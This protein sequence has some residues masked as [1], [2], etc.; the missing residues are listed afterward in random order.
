MTDA[1]RKV[2]E[3]AKANGWWTIADPVED[4]IEPDALAAAL[5]AV[6]PA[7]TA[8]RAG[9]SRGWRRIN[10]TAKACPGRPRRA[11]AARFVN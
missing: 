5:D 1:G 9:S 8:W 4:L 6:P 11:C 2:I 3:V 7:R 10:A